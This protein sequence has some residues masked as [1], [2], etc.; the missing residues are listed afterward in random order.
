M[1]K[2]YDC[3]LKRFAGVCYKQKLNPQREPPKDIQDKKIGCI[4]SM[5][6]KL[7]GG[8]YNCTLRSPTYDF[9]I[10]NSCYTSKW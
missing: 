3:V 8:Q 10:G 6:Q 4:L 7:L 5:G 2:I 1:K 9:E